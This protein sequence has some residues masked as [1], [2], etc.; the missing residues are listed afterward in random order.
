MHEQLC[1]SALAIVWFSFPRPEFCHSVCSSLGEHAR[2]AAEGEVASEA[3]SGA[4]AGEV[5][6]SEER[7]L[8]RR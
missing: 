6:W 2:T 7:E 4:A 1:G 5:D 3:A 8:F